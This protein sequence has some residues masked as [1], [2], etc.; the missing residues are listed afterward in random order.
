MRISKTLVDRCVDVVELLAGQPKGQRLGDICDCLGLPKS[1]AHRLLTALREKGW[2]EQDPETAFYRLTLRL[3]ILG[4]RLMMSTGLPNLCHPV[5]ERL[6]QECGELVRLAVAEGDR[7]YWI[8]SAQGASAGLL[9]QP[10]QAQ[11]VP[12]HVTAAGKAWLA[13]MPTEQAVRFVLEDGFGELSRFGPS[14][15][16]SV[17]ALIGCLNETRQRG[18]AITRDEAEAGVAGV[19]AAICRAGQVAGTIGIEIPIPRSSDRRIGELGTKAAAAANELA[20]LW[21][22]HSIHPVPLALAS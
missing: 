19:A 8:D 17:E 12:L 9:Y 2:V 3:A 14:A 1:A 6:A 15:L 18:W 10:A 13:T 11:K 20:G 5:L 21:T 4:Q 7:L 16:R 22:L